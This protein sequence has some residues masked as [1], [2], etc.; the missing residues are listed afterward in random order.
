MIEYNEWHTFCDA[1]PFV[2]SPLELSSLQN[3]QVFKF[4]RKCVPSLA[5]PICS[6]LRILML[7]QAIDV[8]ISHPYCTAMASL[9]A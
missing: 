9:T 4:S 8:E 6:R 5:L 1:L 7:V 2:T 3:P